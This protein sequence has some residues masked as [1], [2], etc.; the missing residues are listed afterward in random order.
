[1]RADSRASVHANRGH[2]S[3]CQKN[4]W[5]SYCVL[6]QQFASEGTQIWSPQLAPFDRN[7][8]P[9]SGNHE[10]QPALSGCESPTTTCEQDIC[11]HNSLS[12]SC[13]KQSFATLTSTL[14]LK[15][16]MTAHTHQP[17]QGTPNSFRAFT[18]SDDG[19]QTAAECARTF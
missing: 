16:A 4:C 13:V 15:R 3:F 7:T 9:C 12:A 14:A 8:L 5:H 11:R 10:Q 1:M 18:V 6:H 2:V 19:K 17:S